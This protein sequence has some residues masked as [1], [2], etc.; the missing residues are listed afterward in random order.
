MSKPQFLTKRIAENDRMRREE[1]DAAIKRLEKR[2]GGKINP[3]LRAIEVCA[4]IGLSPP[5][6]CG[7]QWK[8]LFDGA[9]KKGLIQTITRTPRR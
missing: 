4:E 5:S 1:F 3:P 8:K 9:R 7:R 6:S 2:Y